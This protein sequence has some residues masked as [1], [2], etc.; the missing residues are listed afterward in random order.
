VEGSKVRTSRGAWKLRGADS[1]TG[2]SYKT[3]V[4]GLK[5]DWLWWGTRVGAGP[6][7]EEQRNT[8]LEEFLGK[9]IE[10]NW[11]CGR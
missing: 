11:K 8:L 9:R 1:Y 6:H 10:E 4:G 2:V 7:G 5:L 3:D